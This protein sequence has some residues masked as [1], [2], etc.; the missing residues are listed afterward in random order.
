V[1]DWHSSRRTVSRS[2]DARN[3]L[4]TLTFPDGNGNQSWTY[5]NEKLGSELTFHLF[6]ENPGRKTRIRVD[7][8]VCDFNRV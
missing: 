4:S 7:F 5:T 3:R 1:R 2:Y 6:S 8:P